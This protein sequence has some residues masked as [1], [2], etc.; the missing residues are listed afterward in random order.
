MPKPPPKDG[1]EAQDFRQN[2]TQPETKSLR[3]TQLAPNAQRHG[4]QLSRDHLTLIN[5]LSIDLEQRKH[6]NDAHP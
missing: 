3:D 5:Q 4:T 1:K 2:I 6:V